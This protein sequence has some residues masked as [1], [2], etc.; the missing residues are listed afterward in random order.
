[1]QYPQSLVKGNSIHHGQKNLWL[2]FSVSLPVCICIRRY[3]YMYMYIC[4]LSVT[5]Y[6][7]IHSDNCASQVAHI[8]LLSFEPMQIHML[9]LFS[10]Y[11]PAPFSKLNKVNKNRTWLIKE[12]CK[13]F[14]LLILVKVLLDRCRE[15]FKTIL[16]FSSTPLKKTNTK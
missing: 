8:T 14:L 16:L 15:T 12:I 13:L 2:C 10:S 6:C 9:H 11:E 5:I 4:M 7:L 3:I 1:M